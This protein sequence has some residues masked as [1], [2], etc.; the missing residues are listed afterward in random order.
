MLRI[1]GQLWLSTI[2]KYYAAL[3]SRGSVLRHELYLL[4]GGVCDWT[5]SFDLYPLGISRG[6]LHGCK[7]H[8]WHGRRRRGWTVMW[9][10]YRFLGILVHFGWRRIFGTG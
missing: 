10:V 2:S 6:H 5:I 3:C 4:W 8:S 7:F 1:H 9:S